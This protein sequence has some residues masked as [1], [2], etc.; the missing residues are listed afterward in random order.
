MSAKNNIS[1]VCRQ[2][3]EIKKNSLMSAKRNK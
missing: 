3:N 2:N 1:R